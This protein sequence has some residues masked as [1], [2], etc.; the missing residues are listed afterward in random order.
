M[1]LE[2]SLIANNIARDDGGGIYSHSAMAIINTTISGNKAETINGQTSNN[3]AGGVYFGNQT[4]VMTLT[5]STITN[6][7]AYAGAGVVTSTSAG[8]QASAFNTIIA[9]NTASDN[10]LGHDAY[11][12]VTATSSHNLIG[13]ATGLYGIANGMTVLN[14]GTSDEQIVWNRIGTNANPVDAKLNPLRD[15]GGSTL[16]H[17]LQEDSPALDAAYIG[18]ALDAN[19]NTL[20]NDQRG[21]GYLRNFGISPDIGAFEWNPYA[22]NDYYVGHR[23]MPLIVDAKQ[24]LLAND[25]LDEEA[26]SGYSLFVDSWPQNGTIELQQD[27]SFV[28]TPNDDFIGTETFTYV[29]ID[30]CGGILSATVRIDIDNDLPVTQ[31][32]QYLIIKNTT[33]EI[34]D[35]YDGVMGN[36]GRIGTSV[37]SNAI[38]AL[39]D[40]PSY[41]TLTLEENG[42]FEYIPQNNFLGLDVFTYRIVLPD[43]T[44]SLEEQVTLLVTAS[45]SGSID[46]SAS[47]VLP[48]DSGPVT[49]DVLTDTS[50]E[51]ITAEASVGSAKIVPADDMT[52]CERIEWTPDPTVTGA[53]TVTYKIKDAQGN[54]TTQTKTFLSNNVP[55][56]LPEFDEN[57]P[58]SFEPGG[59]VY[60]F[61]ATTSLRPDFTGNF[62]FTSTNTR[63]YNLSDDESGTILNGTQT[64][65]RTV[66]SQDF[67]SGNWSYSETVTWNYSV[68]DGP[69]Q[70][71][72]TLQYT[73]LVYAIAGLEYYSLIMTTNDSSITNVSEGDEQLSVTLDMTTSSNV[74]SVFNTTTGAVTGTESVS[75]IVHSSSSVSTKTTE[76]EDGMTGTYLVGFDSDSTEYSQRT[77]TFSVNTNGVLAMTFTGTDGAMSSFEMTSSYEGSDNGG[78]EIDTELFTNM[79]GVPITFADAT[80]IDIGMKFSGSDSATTQY[81][82]TSTLTSPSAN[83]QTGGTYTGSLTSIRNYGDWENVAM[84][85]HGELEGGEN[86]GGQT[87]DEN[88]EI[89]VHGHTIDS[90]R[91]SN[92]TQTTTADW[93]STLGSNGEWGMT[94]GTGS[95]IGTL[96]SNTFLS[97]RQYLTME[98]EEETDDG[99]MTSTTHGYTLETTSDTY[100]EDYTLDQTAAND[101][102]LVTNG[103]NEITIHID[104]ST[105][106]SMAGTY[107]W[108]PE[109]DDPI[110]GRIVVSD[111]TSDAMNATITENSDTSGEW[112]TQSGSGD[113]ISSG[114]SSIIMT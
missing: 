13:I 28:Y 106:L 74:S 87:G 73:L 16:T 44:E 70:N 52:P 100:T 46:T 69:S 72:G 89:T 12:R 91:S 37:A 31:S 23:N 104:D 107:L 11:G 20:A 101:N 21:E 84:R 35:I 67:G 5:N 32:D 99:V 61:N 8:V 26:F 34:T 71:S 9:G 83:V 10:S 45:I 15:N 90:R 7:T 81:T 22:V 54:L 30:C 49:F 40:G 105:E 79:L 108:S 95:D 62:S 98:M 25:R 97:T 6:N 65:K 24:G 39:V 92:S 88:V 76:S 93:T 102:W 114:R 77:N 18:Y 82:I 14:A 113:S 75:T 27:G 41:G 56:V 3:T 80:N 86:A 85:R 2:S 57:N 38:V 103:V 53:V 33:L 110:V 112:S 68:M 55:F 36:D 60:D 64:T 1:I 17:A 109:D 78:R 50:S 51:I 63:P 29:A 66:V 4:A 111:G 96:A 59:V 94:S 19:G 48:N 47:L 58:T 42:T 43:G